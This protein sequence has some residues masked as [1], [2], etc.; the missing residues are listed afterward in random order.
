VW[1]ALRAVVR[2]LVPAREAP[3]AAEV[4]A[5]L[6]R[7]APFEDGAAAGEER[8][9]FLLATGWR[10]GSTLLQR[11]LV[12]DPRLLLWGEPLGRLALLPRLAAAVCGITPGWPPPEFWAEDRLAAEALATGWIANLFPS[13]GDFRAALRQL[14]ERWL[15][16][17]ARQRGFPWWG[18]KEVRLGAAEAVLLRWLFPG[19]RFVVITR[20][21][22]AAFRSVKSSAP[23]WCLHASWP[24]GR[25][26]CVV[27]F[28]RHWNRLAAGWGEPPHLVEPLVLRYEELVGGDFD[29]RRLGEVLDL[30]LAP[31]RALAA[32]P[33]ATL[34]P[35]A[36]SRLER[37]LLRRETAAG[38]R[39][40]GY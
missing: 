8:P 3:T 17:P 4:A 28:A 37:L 10:T 30:D 22:S 7:L 36:L 26:D 6:T 27:R 38:R 34:R 9:L 33:G 11:I 13:A 1:R 16:R 15:A 25:I 5:A 2:S 29:F 19:G 39:V 32:R 31:E 40:M 24:D 21:P 12:S 20:D 23:D 14:F 35:A 18:L